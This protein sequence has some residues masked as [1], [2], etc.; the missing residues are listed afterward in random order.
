MSSERDLRDIDGAA[1]VVGLQAQLRELHAAGC[2]EQAEA[3][4]AAGDDIAQ[5]FLPLELE[6]VV[7]FGVGRYFLP[8]AAEGF[9]DRQIR[10]PD[11][12]GRVGALLRDTL[13]QAGDGGAMVPSIWN[14]T[15]S[16]R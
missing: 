12:L 9:R 8:L 5:E 14:S 2:G 16:S 4:F 13:V 7:E 15:S 3:V 11:G 6:A 10:I 1:L